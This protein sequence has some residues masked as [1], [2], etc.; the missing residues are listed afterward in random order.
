MATVLKPADPEQLREAVAWAAGQ[1]VPLEIAGAGSKGGLGRPVDAEHRLEVGA[2]AGIELYEP[3]ELV[4]SAGAGTPL[5]EVEARLA[6]HG[7]Q[8][9]FEPADLGPLLGSAPGQATIGG[10]FAC[11]LSG[12]RRF[13]AGAARDHLLGLK[14]VSGRGEAFKAGGRV[15]KNV[16]GYDMCK[17]LAGAFGTLAVMTEVTFK[18]LPAPAEMRTV[19]ALGL[20]DDAAIRAMTR[21]L[22]SPFDVSGAAHVPGPLAAHLCAEAVATGRAVTAV[23]I[24]G[25]E[26]SVQYRG[27][28][29]SELLGEFGPVADLDRDS[30][31]VLWREIRDV[32]PFVGEGGSQVW[33]LSVT[34]AAA[35]EVVQ[36]VMAALD[37]R[38]YYDWGGGLIWLAVAG[39]EGAEAARSM[40]RAVRGAVGRAGGHAL[41]VRAPAA[42]RA[43]VPVFHP[44]P[45][46]LARL[47]ARIKESFD[48]RR[49]L[50]PG[51]M[52]DGL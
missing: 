43:A 51:R 22:G 7:Q 5:A 42:V 10:V 12:P 16:T 8:L 13:K 45:E 24:E 4:M 14:A 32:K 19:L 44:Q 28:R 48:P 9:A 35:A 33:R 11:N 21:A 18:V 29:L 3:E 15:M 37:A 36:E 41:L 26:P 20:D 1:G 39:A 38:A 17:L 47:T 50:N 46:A 2:L 31:A 27:G 40:E 23:R 52:Y 25:P 30:S 6:E 49:V 34:P